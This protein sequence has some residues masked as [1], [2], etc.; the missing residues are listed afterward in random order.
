[1]TRRHW[2][3][4]VRE[5]RLEH[6]TGSAIPLLKT[7][8]REEKGGGWGG[9]AILYTSVSTEQVPWAGMHK[10]R[11]LL[12]TLLNLTL[13]SNLNSKLTWILHPWC[14]RIVSL[15]SPCESQFSA[16]WKDR[17]SGPKT[18]CPGQVT[19]QTSHSLQVICAEC[20]GATSHMQ[21]PDEGLNSHPLRWKPG[22]LTTEPPGKAPTYRLYSALSHLQELNT[23]TLKT[24][25]YIQT[26][27]SSNS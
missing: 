13:K 21:N 4:Q 7:G 22:V 10:G 20:L 12:L 11:I 8:Q 24:L 25:T 1:M 27:H 17:Q 16:E 5:K 3:T 26:R 6:T 15:W 23:V 2:Q 9:G 14:I 18:K 19:W